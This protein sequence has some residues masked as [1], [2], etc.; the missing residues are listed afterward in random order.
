MNFVDAMA[1]FALIRRCNAVVIAQSY[2]EGS[3]AGYPAHTGFEDREAVGQRLER[4]DAHVGQ[5]DTDQLRELALVRT[6]VEDRPNAS[7]A[8]EATATQPSQGREPFS[9]S[10]QTSLPTP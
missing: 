5:D 9:R 4:D 1:V 3:E 7:E 2:V 10:V 6:K 8:S